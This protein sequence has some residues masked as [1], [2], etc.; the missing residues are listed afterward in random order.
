MLNR[1]YKV[2][3]EGVKISTTIEPE[4]ENTRVNGLGLTI[5]DKADLVAFLKTLTDPTIATNS[6]F[7]EL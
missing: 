6:E 4:I 3:N 1:I 5:Q 2:Y 7:S